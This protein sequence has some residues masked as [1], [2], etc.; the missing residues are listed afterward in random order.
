M[1]L[2][3]NLFQEDKPVTDDEVVQC[4]IEEA[5]EQHQLLTN[6]FT[7]WK[8][9]ISDRN[10]LITIR[11]SFHTLKGSGRMVDANIIGELAWSI[12]NMLNKLLD[13]DIQ[14]SAQMQELLDEVIQT[15]PEL[16]ADFAS[17][18]QQFTPEVLV[19]MEKADALFKGG[20][21]VTD[22]EDEFGENNEPEQANQESETFE[23]EAGTRHSATVSGRRL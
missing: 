11:R 3:K 2:L 23:T 13:G 4:F 12:E 17:D 6:A 8:Q 18:N 14:V 21:F 7:H 16:V 10:S 22:E 20:L 1:R 9:Q 15:L 19:F 5:G